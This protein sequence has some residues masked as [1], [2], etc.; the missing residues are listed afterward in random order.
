M[1]APTS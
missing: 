1:R